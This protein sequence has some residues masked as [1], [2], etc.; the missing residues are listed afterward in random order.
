MRASIFLLIFV[1]SA[2]AEELPSQESI[3]WKREGFDPNEL[4]RKDTFSDRLTVNYLFSVG[5]MASSDGNARSGGT[6]LSLL[7][8]EISPELTLSAAIGFSSLF[9]ASYS[10]NY[11]DEF[12][13]QTLQ[14]EL[15]IPFIALDYHPS[16]NV[17]MR[18][19]ISDG[20]GDPFCVHCGPFRR[21]PY[22]RN[23]I[24]CAK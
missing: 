15:R 9:F 3:P 2:F 4:L 19:E 16:E 10:E 6:Y 20:R 23:S 22:R 21:D 1:L 24:F 5:V 11:P 14:P 8:Y 18:L 13:R 17:W 7:R 12:R